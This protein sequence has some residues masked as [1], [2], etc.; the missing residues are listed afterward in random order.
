MIKVEFIDR[1]RK[2]IC[3]EKIYGRAALSLLYGN[4]FLARLFSFL[5]LP[6]LARFPI[7]S[8]MVGAFQK[9]ASTRKRIIPFIQAYHIDS[10]EFADPVESFRS[11]NDFFIRKLKSESRPID[12]RPLAAI[13]PVDGRYR[14]IPDLSEADFFHVKG[15]RFDLASFV[16][17]SRLTKLY[18]N[19]AMLIARLNPTDYHRFHFPVDGV[20]G[21]SRNIYGPLFRFRRLL[22]PND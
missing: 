4:S 11:F 17:D 14:V 10:K 15:Q 22:W 8:H 18:Q 19:G 20:P 6:F 21:R 16:Q 2:K 5:F 13:L 3:R 7:C 12:P 1:V 9:R